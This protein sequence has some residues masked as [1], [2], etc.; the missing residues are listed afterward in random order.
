MS[1]APDAASTEVPPQVAAVQSAA[2]RWL[3]RAL[4]LIVFSCLANATLLFW[5]NDVES[6][7]EDNWREFQRHTALVAGQITSRLEERVATQTAAD[8]SK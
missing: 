5:W 1:S 7:Q 4:P 6:R 3:L 2:E 8:Q